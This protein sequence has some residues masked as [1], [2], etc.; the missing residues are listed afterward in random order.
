MCRS[1]AP[2]MPEA[3]SLAV[4]DLTTSTPWNSVEGS[5][6]KSGCCESIWSAVMNTSPLSMVPTCGRPRTSTEVPTPASRL[7]CTPV[8]RCRESVMVVSGSA[9]MFSAVMLSWMLAASRLTSMAWAC[10]SRTPVTV[11]AVKLVTSG[12]L[13]SWSWPDLRVDAAAGVVACVASLRVSCSPGVGSVGAVT[14]AAGSAANRDRVT[15]MA[16]GWMR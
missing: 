5:I 12:F 10:D 8:M 7:I 1:I 6:V 2:L 4:A 13:P 11:T 14:A 9:P 16:S 15:A 3:V